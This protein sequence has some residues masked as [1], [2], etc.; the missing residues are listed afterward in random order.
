MQNVSDNQVSGYCIL[1]S[2]PQR[3]ILQGETLKSR[4]FHVYPSVK[5]FSLSDRILACLTYLLCGLTLGYVLLACGT[6]SST[7]TW[8]ATQYVAGIPV[9]GD[10]L[11]DEVSALASVSAGI[12]ALHFSLDNLPTVI[13]IHFPSQHIPRICK[14]GDCTD[15]WSEVPGVIGV[16]E[17]VPGE[18]LSGLQRGGMI[19]VSRIGD[20]A[21]ALLELLAHEFA[22][23]LCE[24]GD[25]ERVDAL[26]RKLMEETK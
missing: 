9:C 8:P 15:I 2:L 3:S 18:G 12:S 25:G 21:P 11:P 19:F 23:A 20:R 6:D 1:C 17:R 26:E 7:E 10:V 4:S 16:K 24:C 22:H 5:E 14:D 13:F